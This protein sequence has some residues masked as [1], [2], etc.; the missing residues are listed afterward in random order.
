MEIKEEFNDI[1]LE[2]HKALERLDK[3]DPIVIQAVY[4]DKYEKMWTTLKAMLNQMSVSLPINNS[5]IAEHR[6]TIMA[7]G[8]ILERMEDKESEFK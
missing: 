5:S 4:P 6:G 3:V 7:I 8:Y 2:L 1:R